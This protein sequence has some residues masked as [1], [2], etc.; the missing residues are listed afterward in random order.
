MEVISVHGLRFKRYLSSQEI[1]QR[2]MQLAAALRHDL[3]GS[4]P[5]F[6]G[7]LNGS[8]IFAADLIRALDFP[9][10]ITF[11]KLASYNGLS[12]T[13]HVQTL[14]GLDR[15]VTNRM[16]VILEDIID[17]G[18]T[19]QSVLEQWQEL[20]PQQVLIAT[21]LFKPA[22][23]QVPLTPHYIGFRVPND[24]LIGYGLDYNGQGRNL[25]DI[26]VKI[27]EN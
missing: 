1:H 4:N 10:E 15:P 16:V 8:F 5:L 24:F 26:Y 11:I 12:S 6:V 9:C 14:L 13:G 2:I 17:T 21:L 27:T 25:K 23:L 20:H 3:A 19:V 22:A 7:V 18:L